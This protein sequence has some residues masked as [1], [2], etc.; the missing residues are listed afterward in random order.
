LSLDLACFAATAP[1]ETGEPPLPEFA[2]AVIGACWKKMLKAGKSLHDLDDAA[3]HEVRL[4]AKRLRYA[5]EFF[6]PLFA[7]KPTSRFIRRLAALQ[8]RMGVFN[9]AAGAEDLL[10]DL[11]FGA[12]H[13]GGLVLGFTA[14]RGTGMRPRIAAAWERLRRRDPFWL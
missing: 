10:R 7:E 8:E 2:A 13:A 12:G 4:K 11:S 1:A 14:A 9:D 3:L 5:A 6:A